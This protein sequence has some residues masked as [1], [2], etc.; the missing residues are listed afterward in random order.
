MCVFFF[1]LKSDLK[2]SKKSGSVPTHRVCGQRPAWPTW[3]EK[4]GWPTCYR[5]THQKDSARPEWHGRNLQRVFFCCCWM[6]NT[7]DLCSLIFMVQ[8]W[9]CM[10]QCAASIVDW[11]W[12]K[13]NQS[14]AFGELFAQVTALWP[15]GVRKSTR[16]LLELRDKT[17][18]PN[19]VS[20]GGFQNFK[21]KKNSMWSEWMNESMND[22]QLFSVY[23]LTTRW[24]WIPDTWPLY[25]LEVTI[26]CQ[27]VVLFPHCCV[28]C[29]LWNK[30]KKIPTCC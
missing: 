9:M 16:L 20:N 2:Q 25:D 8:V 22:I 17:S 14:V 11:L 12:N 5:K 30:V 6:C 21:T 1:F 26:Q 7:L 23:L 27:P 28:H 10:W 19:E 3:T 29:S 13:F 24:C 18:K 4:T 15:C